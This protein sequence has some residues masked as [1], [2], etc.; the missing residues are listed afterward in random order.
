MPQLI[1]ELPSYHLSANKGSISGTRNRWKVPFS[2]SCFTHPENI[3][4]SHLLSNISVSEPS[5]N[6]NFIRESS[7]H[8]IVC[9]GMVISS[10]GRSMTTVMTPSSKEKFAQTKI[11]LSWSL[12]P[13][14]Q[15]PSTLAQFLLSQKATTAQNK[16]IKIIVFMLPEN[17]Y[18]YNNLIYHKRNY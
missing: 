9:A 2:L 4:Y 13:P 10:K 11:H 5:G 7:K 18:I 3:T 16:R 17:V 1:R 8:T 6:I 14:I 15:S 12:K